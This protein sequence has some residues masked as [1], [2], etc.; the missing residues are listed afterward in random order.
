MNLRRTPIDLQHWE[1]KEHFCFF[2]KMD[3]PFFGLTAEIECT[4]AHAHAKARGWSFFQYYHYL[5]IQTANSIR[6]FKIR[7]E[8][9]QVVEYDILRVS[10][11]ILRPDKTFAFT[12]VEYQENFED[13]S[14]A[15]D[16]EIRAVMQSSGLRLRVSGEYLDQIHFS[17]LPWVKFTSISHARDLN[18]PDSVPKISFGKLTKRDNRYFMPVSVTVHHALMDGYHVGQ[19]VQQFEAALNGR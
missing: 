19:F 18:N 14:C 12:I 5:A 2:S 6:E 7:I 16:K 10:T 1:R 11:T 9:E 4:Q 15:F 17:T 3:E 13:F 8:N